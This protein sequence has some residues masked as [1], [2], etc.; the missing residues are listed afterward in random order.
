MNDYK[1]SSLIRV[2]RES[3]RKL[4]GLVQKYYAEG[5]RGIGAAADKAISDAWKAANGE[6]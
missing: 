5:V 1:S 6:K 4:F 3:K 2:T